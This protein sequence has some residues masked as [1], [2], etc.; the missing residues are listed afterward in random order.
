MHGSHPFGKKKSASPSQQMVTQ[1]QIDTL[2]AIISS[3]VEGAGYG[4]KRTDFRSLNELRQILNAMKDELYGG[5]RMKQVRM[6]SPS[7]KGL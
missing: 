7:D 1:A 2:E 6:T 5:I 3:G 4:D